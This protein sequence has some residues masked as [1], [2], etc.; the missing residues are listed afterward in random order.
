MPRIILPHSD[1]P[2]TIFTLFDQCNIPCFNSLQNCAKLVI[3]RYALYRLLKKELGNPFMDVPI[4]RIK[5]FNAMDNVLAPP[6]V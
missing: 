5:A 4:F 1:L 2:N 6:P 3:H